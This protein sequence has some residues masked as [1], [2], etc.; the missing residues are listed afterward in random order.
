[1]G[2]KQYILFVISDEP[3]GASNIDPKKVRH[4]ISA[5]V[6]LETRG[7]EGGYEINQSIPAP[8]RKGNALVNGTGFNIADTITYWLRWV[9]LSVSYYPLYL[10][11]RD[12]KERVAVDR[13]G[14]L[15]RRSARVI[16]EL[17]DGSLLPKNIREH[18]EGCEQCQ[19]SI[20]KWKPLTG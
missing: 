11:R 5:E 20:S 3:I 2:K 16:A 17:P 14:H 12:V 18:I 10:Q 1:M 13:D 4:F 7:D 19:K 8:C 9:C 15:D 6:T